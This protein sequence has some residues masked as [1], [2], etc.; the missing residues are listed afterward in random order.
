MEESQETKRELNINELAQVERGNITQCRQ[1][2]AFL[3]EELEDA[4]RLKAESV[5]RMKML[6]DISKRSEIKSP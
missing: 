6:E 4:E 5:G 2:V 1:R 3:K